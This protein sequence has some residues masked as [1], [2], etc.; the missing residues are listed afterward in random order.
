MISASTLILLSLD[1]IAVQRFDYGYPYKGHFPFK[2]V[3]K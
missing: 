2:Y 1:V 3:F